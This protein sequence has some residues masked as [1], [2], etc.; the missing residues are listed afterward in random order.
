MYAGILKQRF[1]TNQNQIGNEIPQNLW[2]A[3]KLKCIELIQKGK[4]ATQKNLYREDLRAADEELER[5]WFLT[6]RDGARLKIG[7]D[8][9]LYWVVYF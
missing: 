7:K 5:V 8:N 2:I 9:N 3:K 1:I 6:Q 4:F